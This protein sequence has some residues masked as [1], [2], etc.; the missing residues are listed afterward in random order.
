MTERPLALITGG[1]SGIGAEFARQVA[2]RGYDLILVARRAD[3]LEARAAELRQVYGVTVESLAADLAA[4]EGCA[5]VE[6]RIR[7]AD[8]LALL[9]NNAGFGQNGALAQVELQP[10]LD[11]LNLHVVAT[12]RLTHAALPGMVGAARRWHYQRGLAGRV[13]GVAR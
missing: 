8:R 6:R 2:G 11:M 13:H 9:V 5:T 10:Q 3:R 1:S 4:E 12:M 7:A